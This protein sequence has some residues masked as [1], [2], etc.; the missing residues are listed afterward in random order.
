MIKLF[1]AFATLVIFGQSFTKA[2]TQNTADTTYNLGFENITVAQ[3]LPNKWRMFYPAKGYRCESTGDVKH[4]GNRALLIEQTEPGDVRSFASVVQE[5]PAKFA[6]K[7]IEFKAWLKFENV[8]NA[9]ALMIRI[10][11]ALPK[12]V[13][14]RSLQAQQI[15][16]TKDWAQYSV[17][18]NIPVDA[19]T[20]YVTP[21]L[22]GPGKLW[23][24]DAEVLI[25][26]INI[27]EAKLN[28][29][30]DPNHPPYGNNNAVSGTVKLKDAN[31]YYET[32]GTGQPL[33]LLHG[34]SQ[35]IYAFNFQ[36]KALAEKYKVIAVDTRGQGKSTDETT[37][38]LSYN[39]FAD[40]MKQLMDSL[41]IK[42]AS[43]LGWSDGGNTGLIMAQQY[44][45][46]VNKLAVMGANLFP[47]NDALPDTV[48]NQ[49][50]QALAVYKNSSNAK[51][52]M[53]T[54]LFNMLL[55]EPHL[56]FNDV[57]KIKSPVLVM[58]GEHDLILE[59]HTRAIAAAIP[60]SKLVIFKGA[61]HYAPVDIVKEFNKTVL[62]FLGN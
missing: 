15:R 22:A 9:V 35:S 7:T 39:I 40:D 4:S 43:I 14:Y 37:G 27:A 48:L 23:V 31:I 13:G 49:V 2:A 57:R 54:R 26:G 32:Y 42:K 38:P 59:K 41:H 25:D 28:P 19:Q 36:I 46:Y 53:Q 47:T 50:K 16:G 6:G 3:A 56:T 24:D 45:A 52:K 33:L 20:I 5:I 30:F 10:D 17:K 55:T 11:N 34:N 60:K 29:D 61:T 62:A 21:L 58:A 12:M 18:V 8:T 51:A 1:T 44:P